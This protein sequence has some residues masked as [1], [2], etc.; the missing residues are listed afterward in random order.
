MIINDNSSSSFSAVASSN[1]IKTVSIDITDNAQPI[2]VLTSTSQFEQIQNTN[3]ISTMITST[4]VSSST[5]ISNNNNDLMEVQQ[6]FGQQK[7]TGLAKLPLPPGT[8]VSELVNAK[9]P[10]PPRSPSTPM[11]MKFGLPKSLS[12]ASSGKKGLLNLPM[13]PMVPGSEDVSG[14]ENDEISPRPSGGANG[15]RLTTPNKK[16]TKAIKRPIILNRRNSRS[17]VGP[18]PG[19]LDWGERSVDVFEVLVQIG[20]GTYGQVCFQWQFNFQKT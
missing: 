5:V 6:Q 18:G 3:T 17:A 20:E 16:S 9:T 15:S 14:D 8:N 10:S 7:K 4:N 19:G 11:K 12:A 1:G 13:P 2:P